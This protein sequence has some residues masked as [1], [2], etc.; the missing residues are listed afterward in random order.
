METIIALVLLTFVSVFL[1]FFGLN[2]M[3]GSQSELIESRLDRYAGATGVGSQATAESKDRSRIGPRLDRVLMLGSNSKQI[4]TDLARA[5]LKL[6]PGEWILLNLCAL[7]F[8][9]L[10]V[11]I[12]SGNNL[13]LALVGALVGFYA[14]R[15]YMRI[16]QSRR[17]QA[18]NNQLG[19][20]LLL[21]SNSLRSGY[22]LLQSMESAA[23][24]LTPPMSTE[25]ARVVRE[26]GLGLTLEE[27]LAHL[28]ERIDSE[29]L[30]MA[31]TAINIQHEV[32]GN[33]AE[34]LDTISHT[35]RE[36]VRIKGQ[37]KALT[38]QQ[39]LSGTVIAL[40]PV[41]VGL[42]LL[43]FNPG[44]VS[45]LWSEPCGIGMLIYG[46]VSMIIGYLIIRK[47]MAIEV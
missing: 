5:D 23:K 9:F 27:A 33:L 28:V 22:S 18:F 32:G 39:Q 25:F 10:F 30:D 3:L 26:I 8:G 45:G 16:M 38:A 4:Q 1:L 42:F 15:M 21:L 40:L 6:T 11:L 13:V 37:I 43:G 34:I 44:Y 12:I 20:T 41:F 36:R 7:F 24:E 35:I 19:D 46:A 2:R 29:D 47:I 31:V 17:L 14:P